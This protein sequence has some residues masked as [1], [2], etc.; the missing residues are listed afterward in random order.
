[1]IKK[2]DFFI[3]SSNQL[4]GKNVM[5]T[6]RYFKDVKNIYKN[7]KSANADTLMYTVKSTNTGSEDEI[8]S[9]QWGITIM[10]PIVVGNEYNMTKGHLHE[11]KNCD[12][13]YYCVSGE[14]VLIKNKTN[15]TP[16]IEYMESG[17]LHYISGDQAH[18]CINTGPKKLVFL[19]AWSPAAGYEY[20]DKITDKFGYRVMNINDEITLEKI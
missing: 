3:D 9:L 13:Y 14:G 10:E 1:M 11:N 7:E 12:E 8:G 15:N 2:T 5:T 20:G 17:S 19:A 18:R 16:N 6:K 4:K